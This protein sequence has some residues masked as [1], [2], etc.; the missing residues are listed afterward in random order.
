[1]MMQ[2]RFAPIKLVPRGRLRPGFQAVFLSEPPTNTRAM[3]STS[4]TTK[5]HNTY[6]YDHIDLKHLQ[7]LH[8]MSLCKS[9][10]SHDTNG[11]NTNKGSKPPTNYLD[12]IDINIDIDIDIYQ[13]VTF[14]KPTSPC[15][16]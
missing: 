7:N 13:T 6:S 14:K 2:I 8:T 3:T 11:R 5:V 15:F 9:T 10:H 16:T 4:I 1:M 12:N